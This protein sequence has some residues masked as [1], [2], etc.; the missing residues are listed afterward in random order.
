MLHGFKEPTM[1]TTT[2][3]EADSPQNP[4]EESQAGNSNARLS[5]QTRGWVT[6]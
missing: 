4:K 5:S 6:N 1:P 3:A 2:E